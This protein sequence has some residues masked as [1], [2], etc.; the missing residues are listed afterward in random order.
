MLI[1]KESAYWYFADNG[2]VIYR[3]SNGILWFL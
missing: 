1:D 3:D 2:V